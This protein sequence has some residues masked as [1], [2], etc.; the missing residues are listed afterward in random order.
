VAI[1]G[2]SVCVRRR[3]VAEIATSDFSNPPRARAAESGDKVPLGCND[4]MARWD[5]KPVPYKSIP[6]I[7]EADTTIFHFTLF[8]SYKKHPR[9]PGGVLYFKP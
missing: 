8:I 9:F 2:K 5:G 3:N 1:Y 4:K 6:I 7:R